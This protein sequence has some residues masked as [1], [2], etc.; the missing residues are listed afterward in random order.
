MPPGIAVIAGVTG[1]THGF[2]PRTTVALVSR[3]RRAGAV[4]YR[5]E[6]RTALVTGGNSGLG[7]AAARAFALGGARVMLAARRREQG[8]EAVRSIRADGGEAAFVETDVTDSRSVR[9]MVAACVDRFGRLDFAYNNAGITGHVHT[10]IADA[11]E[12]MFERV[13]ATNVRGMWLSM[14][15]EVPAILAAG[16]GA[17]VNCSSGAGLRGGPRSS[18]YYASKHAVLGMTKSVALEYAARGIR[19]NAIC[20]GLTMTD[21]VATGFAEA[22]DKL[23]Y[24]SGRIPM[25]RAGRPDEVGDVVTWLCSDESSFMTGAAIPVDGGTSV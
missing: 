16:G 13:I 4:G 15:Y 19:V 14:K 21:I 11:D 24:L 5:F 2:R 25:G 20:P 7:L 10:E 9:A 8:E 3:D 17:I 1:Y 18:A 6:G 22:P 23:A 12:E